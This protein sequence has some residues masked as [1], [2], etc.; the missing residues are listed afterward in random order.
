MKYHIAI[1]S[2]Q[3][4]NLIKEKTLAYLL[5]TDVDPKSITVFL[6]NNKELKEYTAMKLGVK[7]VVGKETLCAQRKFMRRYYPSGGLV[8]FIDDDIEG[9]YTFTT[10]RWPSMVPIIKLDKLIKE[11]FNI[12]ATF[13]C[14]LWGIYPVL[15]PL[16]IFNH[17]SSFDLKYICG[18]VYGEVIDRDTFLDVTM[19]DKEDFERTI[20]HFI[21]NLSVFRWNHISMKTR[22][23]LE[24]GGMQVTRTKER[25]SS[26][27]NKLVSMFPNHCVL[28]KSKRNQD[29]AEV[30]LIKQ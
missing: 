5:K 9:I 29:F 27:A 3:R 12:C 19:E 14:S 6:A 22:Y 24:D 4:S 8:F 13:N 10:D 16:F 2:Y 26:S 7:L 28:N 1:P 18:A 15:N 25:V 23:Y 21:K 17:R 11:S 20:R 30:K